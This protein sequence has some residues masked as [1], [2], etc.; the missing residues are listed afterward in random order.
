MKNL[1]VLI[2]FASLVNCSSSKMIVDVTVNDTGDV[3]VHQEVNKLIDTLVLKRGVVVNKKYLVPKNDDDLKRVRYPKYIRNKDFNYVEYNYPIPKRTSRYHSITDSIFY[4]NKNFLAN[5]NKLYGNK[6][7]LDIML[8]NDFQLIYPYEK[9]KNDSIDSPEIIAGHFIKSNIN[10]FEVFYLKPKS[11]VELSNIIDV[12]DDSFL[13]FE[14][15]LSSKVNKPRLIFMPVNGSYNAKTL[16]NTIVFNENRDYGDR[17]VVHEVAHLWWSKYVVGFEDKILNEA[18]TEFMALYYLNS[19]NKRDFVKEE[20]IKKNYWSEGLPSFNAFKKRKKSINRI[21]TLS[22]L[23]LPILL[24]HIQENNK[25]FI[26]KLIKVFS[27]HKKSK[28][29][30]STKE[31]EDL[32]NELG[33]SCLLENDTIL[34]DYYITES[35]NS[36]SV[37]SM[38]SS[39]EK[40][41]IEYTFKDNSVKIDSIDVSKTNPVEIE[42]QNLHKLIIDPDFKTLQFSKLND[43][44]V[45]NDS[46][47]FSKSKYFTTIEKDS[48]VVEISS[49]VLYYLFEDKIVNFNSDVEKNNKVSAILEKVKESISLNGL[50]NIPNGASVNYAEEKNRINLK[51]VYYSEDKMKPHVISLRI[52]V[53]DNIENIKHVKDYTL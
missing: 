30:I 2:L 35:N 31:F 8:P 53:D 13:F 10:N 41:P 38:S 6:L 28:S 48:R 3:N 7:G 11:K 50:N 44:W 16:K 46:S 1:L 43:I 34:T 33:Y 29:L 24:N 9:M 52:S 51:V 19:I 36:V 14:K 23:F 5:N 40:I 18:V 45:N 15:L 39:T 12:V 32:L 42:K 37:N 26:D 47:L 20:L 27:E 22:Y 4:F 49:N 21:K 17:T 25:S